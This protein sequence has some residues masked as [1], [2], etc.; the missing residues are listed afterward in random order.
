MISAKT[1]R[2]LSLYYDTAMGWT[3]E[4]LLR[5]SGYEVAFVRGDRC[6]DDRLAGPFDLALLCQL[7]DEETMMQL[8][9]SLR[10]FNLGIR[11]ILVNRYL[12]A[13]DQSA[14]SQYYIGDGPESRPHARWK[15]RTLTL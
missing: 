14:D 4:I 6:P 8:M 3:H 7:L 12:R 9:E 1:I 2:I 15:L 11:V 13:G 5:Q 10:E